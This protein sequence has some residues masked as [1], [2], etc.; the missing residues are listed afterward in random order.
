ME[1]P[2]RL[3]VGDTIIIVSVKTWLYLVNKKIEL[4]RVK[5]KSTSE[6]LWYFSITAPNM[7]EANYK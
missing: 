3:L 5:I 1:G 4:H 7:T 6:K 2:D